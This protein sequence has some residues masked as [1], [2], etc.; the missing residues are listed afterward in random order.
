MVPSYIL[1]SKWLNLKNNILA[2][3]LP[4]VCSGWYILMMKGFF[5]TVP[6]SMIESAKIDGAKELYIFTRIVMPVS[7]PAFATIGLFYILGSWNDWWLSLLYIESEKLVK[8]QYLL[9]KVLSNIEFL[10]SYDA[11]RY[12][13]VS[14]NTQIPTYSTRMA[15]CI[16]ATGPII[17]IFPFFQKYF[18]KGITIGAVKG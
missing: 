13:L 9:M 12:G 3:I 8:L 1:I 11:L 14:G 16:L 7:K 6:T 4:M 5:Q 15:M 10:N 17:I 2:L 18:V